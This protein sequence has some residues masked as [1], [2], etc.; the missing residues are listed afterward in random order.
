M[1]NFLN[2]LKWKFYHWRHRKE[3]AEE[4]DK[5]MMECSKDGEDRMEAEGFKAWKEN[6]PEEFKQWEESG[7]PDIF[8]YK[9]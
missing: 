2:D 1:W 9:K 4:Y 6:S 7:R 5:L 3:Q 8:V